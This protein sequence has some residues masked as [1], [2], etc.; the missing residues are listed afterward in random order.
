MN[1]TVELLFPAKESHKMSTKYR[2]TLNDLYSKELLLNTSKV[3][4]DAIKEG[5]FIAKISFKEEYLSAFKKHT[6]KVLKEMGYK[7]KIKYDFYGDRI[8]YWANIKW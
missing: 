3:I 8:I 5:K 4:D 1:E 2:E 7:V 6:Q